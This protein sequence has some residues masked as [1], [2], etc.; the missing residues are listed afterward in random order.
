MALVLAACSGNPAPA[1]SSSTQSVWTNGDFE[2]DAIGTAPPTGW[3]RNT[4]LNPGI[5]D[6]RPSAQTLASLNLGAGGV[7]LTT[8]I[9]GATESQIDPDIGASGSLRYPKYGQR[10]AVVNNTNS[11]KNKNANSLSQQM[12]VGLGDVDPT[13]NKVHVRFAVAPVLEN[14]SHSYTDQP[15]Y[16]VRLQNVTT[17]ATLYQ[18]FNA[19]GQPGVPW[20]DFTDTSGF[21]AQYTNWQLVDISPGNAFLSVGDQVQLLVVAAGCSQGGHWG[22]VYIDAVGSGIPGLYAWAT[23]A[24]QANA[25]ADVT[26]TINYKNGGTTTSNGTKIDLVTPPNTVYKST[27]GTSCTAPAVGSTGTVSCTLGTL[28]PGSTGSYTLTV[29]IS[30]GTTVG[31]QIT[32]G[33]YQIYATGVSALVGPKVYTTVTSGTQYANL[34]ITKTDSVAAVGWG[35]ADTYTIVVTNQG[36]VA[37]A[38]TVTDTM[39][40]QLTGVTWACAATGGGTCTATG[41]NDISDSVSLPVGATLTYT[42]QT[43]IASG[44]GSSSIVNEATVA[45]TGGPVDPDSNDNAVVDTDAVGTLRTLAVTKQGTAT[46]GSITSTPAAISCGATCSASFL[47]SSQVVLTAAPIAGATFLGWGGACS[48]TATTCTVTMAGAQNVTANFVGAASATAVSTGSPQQAAVSTAFAT[49]LAVLVTDASGTPVPGVTVAFAAPGSG[50]RATLSAAS[51]VTDTNGLASITATANATP[52]VYTV[53]ATVSGITPVASF[54]LSNLGAPSSITVASGSSQSATVATPFANLVAVVKDAANQVVPNATVTFSAPGSGASATLGA[55]SATT[56]ASGNAAITASAGTVSGTYAVTASTAGVALPATFSLT[57]TAGAATALVVGAGNNQ[58]ATV[59]TAFATA[60][61]AKV[62]DAYGNG[63]AGTPVTFAA[64]ASLATATIATPT[65]TSPSSGLVS[66]SAT[67]SDTTG[68]YA[69]TASATGLSSIVFLLTNTAATPATIFALGGGGQSTTVHTAFAAPL[70]AFVRDVYGNAVPG[71]TVTFTAPVATATATVASAT[72]DSSGVATTSAFASNGAGSYAVTGAIGAGSVGYALTNTADAPATV[73]ITGGNNQTATVGQ[74]FAAI[75]ITVVDG[76]GNPVPNATV[77]LTGPASGAGIATT[78]TTVTTNASGIA[79]AS[80]TANHTAGP[81]TV[82]ASVAGVATSPAISLT[83]R[84]GTATSLAVVSGDTQHAV[85]T[86]A[87]ASSLVVVARDAY[88]NV[89]PSISVVFTASGATFAPASATTDTS[90]RATTTATAGTAAGTYTVTATIP[91]AT[92]TFTLTNDPGAAATVAVSG[93]NSQTATVATA[94][95]APLAVHVS[96]AHGNDVPNATVAFT[97]PTSGARA[98]LAPTSATTD[99]TGRASITAT[100]GQI[101][102]AYSVTASVTGATPATFSL[103]NTADVVAT[104][105]ATGGGG[106]SA[107]VLAPFAQALAVHAA[108]QY[109]NAVPSA[110]IAFTAPQ[111]TFAGTGNAVT[112]PGGN[113]QIVATAGTLA[114]S[115]AATA[116]SNGATATFALTNTPGAAAVISVSAGSDQAATV[117]QAY[118]GTLRALVQDAQGNAV[119]NATVTFA[120]P[121]SPATAVLAATTVTTGSDGIAGTTATA[122]TITGLFDVTASITG[123]S[124]AFH[125]T[126]TAD[127]PASITAAVISTPQQMT[128][129]QPYAAPLAVTVRDRFSNAVP[130]AAVTFSAPATQPSASLS[131]QTAT[132]DS[133]GG[134]QVIATAGPTA[135]TFLVHASVAG[136]TD[137]AAFSLSNTA[138]QPASLTIAGGDGQATAVDTDF[139]TA[140]AVLVLDAHGNPVPNVVVGFAAPFATATAIL[141]ASSAQTD[142]NGIATITARAS[143]FTGN[144]GVSASLSGSTAPVAFALTNTAGPATTIV[145]SPASTPQN[146]QVD[147]AFVAPLVARVGDAFGNNVPGAVVTFALPAT[148]ATGLA[149]APQATTGSDGR[150]TITITAGTVAGAYAVTAATTGVAT[151]AVFRLANLPGAAHTITVASGSPQIATVAS[152]FTSPIVVLVQDDHGNAVPSTVVDFAVPASGPSATPADTSV[153]TAADGT[154][155]TTLLAGTIAGDFFVTATTPSGSAPAVFALTAQPGAPATATAVASATPQSAEVLHAFAH[156]LAVL[157]VDAYGNRVPGVTVAYEAPALPGAQLSAGSA[158]TGADGIASVLAIADANAGDYT[159]TASLAGTPDVEFA[160]ANT[161]ASPSNVVIAGGGAQH[162]LATTAFAQPVALH[163]TDVFGNPVPATAI[164][165]VMPAAGPTA[166]PSSTS[167]VTDPNGDATVSLVAGPTV[168]TFT[169]SAHVDGA[170]TPA[171]SVFA[172]DAIPTTTTATT[173]A[174]TPVDDVVHVTITVGSSHGTPDGTVELVGTDGMRYGSGTLTGGTATVDVAGLALGSHTLTAHYAAHGSFGES[175]SAAA[176]VTIT[177]DTGSLS[178]GGCSTSFGGSGFLVVLAVLAFVLRRRSAVVAIGVVAARLA[179]AEP[180]GARAIDRYHAAAADSAWFALDSAGFSGHR[181]VSLSFVGDYARQPLDIYAADGSVRE[182]VVTDAFIVQL[183]GSVT[184]YDILRLSATVPMAPW[185]DGNGGTY[186]GMPLASPVTAFGDVSLA[187]DVRVVGNPTG[188]FRIATGVRFTLPSG[189]TTNFMSDGRLAVEPRV[190]AAGT[191]GRFEYAAAASAFLR[192][193]NQVAGA[194]FGSE[195]RYSAAAGVHL[196]A[197]RLLV[198]PELVGAVPLESHTEIGTPL[199]IQAGVHYA[200]NR[201]FRVSAGAAMGI[202]NAIGEPQWRLLAMFTYK[203]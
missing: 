109:G 21:A 190:L 113:A 147:H 64:P 137:A 11:G 51:A 174:T 80:V 35:Q 97:G 149:S 96:D 132:T 92:T 198:G 31:T 8:V 67:A 17:G 161:P 33:N 119:P 62:V 100:A 167:V 9:G 196:M 140:L 42:V 187:G 189:S 29:T 86:A 117:A 170:L 18:D 160:L 195:L 139:A 193:T 53:T 181:E 142:G 124:T 13:D 45:T 125:L 12:T 20:I 192:G 69:I 131:A 136:V 102:G 37:T 38:A 22:R 168:G 155:Q 173:D 164:A 5:T 154:A 94:F 82:T 71:T 40:A 145:A 121:G 182:K 91:G 153:L 128:V 55:T 58:S 201:Q 63:V 88:S 105:T 158:M 70:Q 68:T 25:G 2:S 34:G 60:I 134:A 144:Y 99:S 32:N 65:S 202:I 44:T 110:T 28:A 107:V 203:P 50:P 172:V 90:G 148:G 126:N 178:G 184:L 95:A 177:G 93:G 14:P 48:G 122:S 56:D 39:P 133:S 179:A 1:T 73:S 104:L 74:A 87:F 26:Y 180:E 41:T 159:V 118:A 165:F 27:T 10:A 43:T 30:A 49:P 78:P 129:L 57:N 199:E 197:R 166:T 186:N 106:Q 23:G 156:S 3:T 200:A 24:Q 79:T 141:A 138:G 123:A 46:A 116:S 188:A 4:Y 157:V 76:Y 66:T 171:T 169:F 36:P 6:T 162:A 16:F 135:G 115:Y 85:V 150:A 108:D 146:A 191:S 47:D 127:I 77:T 130:S 59:H 114:T 112:D 176:T 175:A 54:A 84:A 101:T 52:G 83:N 98:T 111:A 81:Y 194:T 151:P 75:Q 143:T 7:A 15:Y 185:Q 152:A 183:G 163:V 120:A 72:T 89:V 61:T 103:T 19:S